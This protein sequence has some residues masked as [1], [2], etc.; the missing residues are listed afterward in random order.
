MMTM[1]AKGGFHWKSRLMRK[2]GILFDLVTAYYESSIHT[3]TFGYD[4][5]VAQFRVR[6]DKALVDQETSWKPRLG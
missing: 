3:D 4:E 5:L 6:L 2:G 1:R